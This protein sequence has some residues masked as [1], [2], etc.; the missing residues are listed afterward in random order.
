MRTAAYAASPW[1][2]DEA[3]LRVFTAQND[4]K[5]PKHGGLGIGTR[6]YPVFHVYIHVQVAFNAADRGYI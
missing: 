3:G 4:F 2:Y 1:S 5:T 6:Y